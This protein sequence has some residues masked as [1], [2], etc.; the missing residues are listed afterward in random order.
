MVA[1][2]VCKT[3]IVVVALACGLLGANSIAAPP[4]EVVAANES[5]TVELHSTV[6][7]TVGM[8]ARIEQH[9]YPGAKLV[10]RPLEDRHQSFVLRISKTYKHGTDHRYDFE[11]YALEPGTY[12]LADYLVRTDGSDA[13]LPPLQV[14][15]RA[16]LPPGQVLPRELEPTQLRWLGGYRVLVGFGIVLW[17]IGLGALLFVGR[18]KP[19]EKRA[20]A[21]A[22]VSLADHLRPL[23]RA[24]RDGSLAPQDRA[25]LERTLISYWSRKLNLLDLQPAELMTRL[26]EHDDA[27]PLITSLELWLH[28]PNPSEPI[29]LDQLL[30]PYANVNEMELNASTIDSNTDNNADRRPT[31]TSQSKPQVPSG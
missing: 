15:V 3:V 13:D 12:N 2:H 30:A 6:V 17:M 21:E 25:A 18:R 29:D 1:Y 14:V 26:R 7:T 10:I 4:H 28:H 24:A 16:T 11:F 27:G 31:S 19:P 22:S 23:V 20:V 8:A 5:G 9:V